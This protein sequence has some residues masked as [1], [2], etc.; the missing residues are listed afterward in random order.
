MLTPL[1]FSGAELGNASA[2]LPS[3]ST[4]TET[5]ACGAN[6]ACAAGRVALASGSDSA[7]VTIPRK[8]SPLG[9]L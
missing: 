5:G 8:S 3:R 9:G 4:W 2:R 1:H 7:S 6:G